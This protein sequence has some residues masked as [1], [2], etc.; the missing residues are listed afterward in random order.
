MSSEDTKTLLPSAHVSLFVTDEGVRANAQALNNDWRYA[1]VDVDVNTGYITTAIEALSTASKSPDLIIVETPTTEETLT[2]QLETLA[3]YCDENTAAIVIGP[4]NDVYLYRTLI[5]MG[6]GDY[7][8]PPIEEDAFADI[9]ARTLIERFGIAG[10]RLIAFV[11]AKGGVGTSALTRSSAQT[12]ANKLNE[13][14]FLLDAAGGWSYLS[15]AFGTEPVTGLRSAV[16]AARDGGEDGFKRMVYK[17][18]ERLSI[19]NCGGDPMLENNIEAKHF[20][21][22][23][24]RLL[25]IY[26]VVLI[27]LSFAPT[28]VMR[29]VTARAN[30][31]I[32]VSTPSLPS[33]RAVRTLM[34]EIADLRGGEN[35]SKS[36][37]PRGDIELLINM[38]G[39]DSAHEV[40]D[41]DIPDLMGREIGLTMPHMPK[42]FNRAENLNE[43]ISDQKQGDQVLEA[44]L[45]L[46]KRHVHSGERG[47]GTTDSSEGGTFIDKF[48]H[49]IKQR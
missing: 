15:V 24:D 31:T 16:R 6:V 7:L 3:E 45:P 40:A 4:V 44:L 2:D 18:G 5:S 32:V 30:S 21:V 11:G 1:R 13:K 36:A 17:A 20:E 39:A 46:M 34:S 27:D 22:L 10:S 28:A 49:W 25:G 37:G 8:V 23:I 9:I 12:V 29:T 33:L 38:Q 47:R 42:I 48:I 43:L 19:L 35:D 41:K 14:T 26:P